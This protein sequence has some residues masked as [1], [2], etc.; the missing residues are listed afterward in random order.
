MART[1]EILVVPEQPGSYT[2]YI[3]IAPS[4]NGAYY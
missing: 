3:N 1:I 4:P 2:G